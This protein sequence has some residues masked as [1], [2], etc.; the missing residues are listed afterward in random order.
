ME[1]VYL[2]THRAGRLKEKVEAAL[3]EL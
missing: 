3:R 2:E 1:P